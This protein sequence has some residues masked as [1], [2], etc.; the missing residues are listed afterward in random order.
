MTSAQSRAN[1][2][3]CSDGASIWLSS[4]PLKSENF[5]LTKRE[6]YDGIHLRYAWD[7]KNLPS[8]CVCKAK[9]NVDHALSCKIGGFVTLRHNEMR[10]LTVD[11]LSTV[12]KDV[13]KEHCLQKSE[14]GVELRADASARGFWQIMQRAFV[15][16]R[17]F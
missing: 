16:V 7:L 15:D 3:A 13:C 9:F 5:S 8:E 12:C 14:N 4:L 10:D 11:L 17:V 6:F 2:I 1:D